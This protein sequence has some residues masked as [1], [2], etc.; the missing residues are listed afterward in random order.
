VVSARDR[1]K[2]FVGLLQHDAAA[3]DQ[4]S[5]ARSVS[6]F[7]TP[8]AGAIRAQFSGPIAIVSSPCLMS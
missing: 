2:A 8:P 7:F 6:S 5:L 3:S 4:F 1:P